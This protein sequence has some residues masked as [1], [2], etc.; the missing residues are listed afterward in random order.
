MSKVFVSH[1]SKDKEIVERI[2]YDLIKNNIPVWLDSYE[3]S[4]GDSLYDKI[5]SGLNESNFIVVV[6]SSN[7]N[8]SFW[9]SKEFKTILAKEERDKKKYL[10]PIRIDSTIVPLEIA[11]RLHQNFQDDFQNSIKQLVRFLKKQEISI[12]A[13]PLSSRQ[14]IISFHQFTELEINIIKSPLIDVDL[15]SNKSYNFLKSQLFFSEYN[16][17]DKI[18]LL[19]KANILLIE[20]NQEILNQFERDCQYIE[21]Y[22]DQLLRGILI[23][24]NSYKKRDIFIIYNSI[25]WFSKAIMT[26]I[27]LLIKRYLKEQQASE[28]I[29]NFENRIFSRFSEKFY[30][31]NQICKVD[32]YDKKNPSLFFSPFINED[33]NAYKELLS[34][35][36]VFQLIFWELFDYESLSKYFIPQNVYA[37]TINERSY[38]LLINFDDY[39][40]GLH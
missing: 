9:T 36:G 30:N 7:Y 23:I 6:I 17:I 14:L 21:D 3:L 18:L 25:Y 15:D 37:N 33:N 5:F 8:N 32:V 12:K 34:Y 27:A 22:I 10:I 1:S 35:G 2:S 26:D 38:P 29:P 16:K 40:V 13:I 19:A 4:I 20:N 11:D 28:F 39:M 24:L 31:E